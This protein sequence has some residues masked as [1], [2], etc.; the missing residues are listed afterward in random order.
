M[1]QRYNK[2]ASYTNT[3]KNKRFFKEIEVIFKREREREMEKI[4][5]KLS[6]LHHVKRKLLHKKLMF[7]VLAYGDG[8]KNIGKLIENGF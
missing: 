4:R 8:V 2:R 7:N 1:P 6:K 3:V 5:L